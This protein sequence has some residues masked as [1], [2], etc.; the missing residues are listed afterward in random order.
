[1]RVN[2]LDY[3]GSTFIDDDPETSASY[4]GKIPGTVAISG[5]SEEYRAHQ[6]RILP[7]VN[8]QLQ[9]TVGLPK[10][11]LD[12]V[13]ARLARIRTSMTIEDDEGLKE[14]LGLSL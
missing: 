10:I 8:L 12:K 4:D 3:P 2:G 13:V 5:Y 9:S 1:M 11:S 6:L 14:F 7:L